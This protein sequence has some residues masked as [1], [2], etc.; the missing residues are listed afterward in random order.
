VSTIFCQ[1]HANFYLGDSTTFLESFGFLPPDFGLLFKTANTTPTKIGR[2]L[3][4]VSGQ[5]FEIL[6]TDRNTTFEYGPYLKTAT[7]KDMAA[8]PGVV[9]RFL[10][11]NGV[12]H[13]GH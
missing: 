7:G 4:A 8:T 5:A 1:L 10:W 12:A 11:D 13:M 3:G 2:F 6:V 9:Y